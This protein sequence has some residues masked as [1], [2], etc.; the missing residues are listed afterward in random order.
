MCVLTSVDL[1]VLVSSKKMF[2]VD[3]LDSKKT[4]CLMSNRFPPSRIDA[5][6]KSFVIDNSIID[7]F[8][9][10]PISLTSIFYVLWNQ[11]IF[12]HLN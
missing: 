1:V 2:T 9:G 8:Q 10:L 6:Q 5:Y 11:D 4:G 12:L 3:R 7:S